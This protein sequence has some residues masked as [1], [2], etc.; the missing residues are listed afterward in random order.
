LLHRVDASKLTVAPP[1][2]V[3]TTATPSTGN[4]QAKLASTNTVSG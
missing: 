4:Y 2:S 3:A 1:T